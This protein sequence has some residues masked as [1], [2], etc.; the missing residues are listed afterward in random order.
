MGEILASNFPTVFI[1]PR[2]EPEVQYVGIWGREVVGIDRWWWWWSGGGGS[3][4]ICRTHLLHANLQIPMELQ[5][6][7]KMRVN[8]QWN[9]WT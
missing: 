5:Y 4:P 9:R 2:Q 7:K 6:V 8:D 3:K 1:P